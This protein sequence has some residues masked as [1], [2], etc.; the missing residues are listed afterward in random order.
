MVVFAALSVLAPFA[1]VG[2]LCYC[3]G[4]SRG[5]RTRFCSKCGHQ[6]E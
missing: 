3:L 5:R 1:L 2:I 6:G 4:R